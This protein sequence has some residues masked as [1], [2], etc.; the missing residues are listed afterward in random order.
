MACKPCLMFL[1]DGHHFVPEGATQ[2]QRI[3]AADVQCRALLE[4]SISSA[5]SGALIS[6]TP[7]CAD[8]GSLVDEWP[9]IEAASA[10]ERRSMHM[11]KI[12]SSHEKCIVGMPV[13]MWPTGYGDG[14]TRKTFA[15]FISYGAGVR[16][17][18]VPK[19]VIDPAMLPL[20]YTWCLALQSGRT[21]GVVTLTHVHNLHIAME[22]PK[23]SE[24]PSIIASMMEELA[25]TERKRWV[26]VTAARAFGDPIA[27][28]IPHSTPPVLDAPPV[29]CF[30]A[31][32]PAAAAAVLHS[33]PPVPDAPPVSSFAAAAAAAAAAV[34]TNTPLHVVD[35]QVT[36][37]VVA[38]ELPALTSGSPS[39]LMVGAADVQSG[40]EP[41]STS[42]YGVSPWSS[43]V[44]SSQTP[45]Q[46]CLSRLHD[47][48][49][50][51][52]PVAMFELNSVMRAAC[53]EDFLRVSTT[54][55][56][57][58]VS[59]FVPGGVKKNR[60]WTHCNDPV[61]FLRV[62]GENSALSAFLPTAVVQRLR[63]ALGMSVSRIVTAVGVC[64]VPAGAKAQPLH[65]DY[66]YL[67]WRDKYSHVPPFDEI[68]M[69]LYQWNVSE[70]P[71]DFWCV[72][73]SHLST[74]WKEDTHP[75]VRMRCDPGQVML[76]N[77]R[78]IH[79]GA[80]CANTSVRLWGDYM[81]PPWVNQKEFAAC[82][83]SL[84]AY[85]A[86]GRTAALGYEVQNSCTPS[87]S[88]FPGIFP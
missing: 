3:T 73:R 41:R 40:E 52:V 15:V 29:S 34:K 18:K 68:D 44:S 8:A 71:F 4:G 79:A 63:C 56:I 80:F 67:F 21:S 57:W 22:M 23:N 61:T 32:A 76:F 86:C 72:P 26:G 38:S 19:G 5:L 33:T 14:K 48:G 82:D 30:A 24:L 60:R 83:A 43:C 45:L 12:H 74:E 59:T 42:P 70:E 39:P 28:A 47:F 58:D 9:T 35:A 69:C 10:C 37:A 65:R 87:S 66:P 53:R 36:A 77:A 54:S 81:F 17:R 50:T 7:G 25:V 11:I 20:W 62:C 88:R 31:A 13:W 64:V 27:G 6:S 16:L 55:S 46:T 85:N 75:P 78:L 49:V 2:R 1:A 84:F 51:S